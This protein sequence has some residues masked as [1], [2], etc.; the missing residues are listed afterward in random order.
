MN[1]LKK[2]DSMT[3]KGSIFLFIITSLLTIFIL[4]NMKPTVILKSDKKTVN[5]FKTFSISIVISF[6]FTFIITYISIKID[7]Q[8]LHKK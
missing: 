1:I 6:I 7:Q 2:I 5:Y 4:L 3:I 8:N